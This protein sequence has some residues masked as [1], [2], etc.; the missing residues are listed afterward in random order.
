M[1][2]TVKTLKNVQVEVQVQETS[3]VEAV[4]E[5]IEQ[6]LPNMPAKTQK[7]IHSGK[8]LKREM[9]IKDYPDIKDGDKVIVIASKVVESSAPQPVAQV[10]EKA[11]ESTPVQQEAPEKPEPVYDNPSSK[12][13]IGQELQDNVNRI[14]EM[15]F[16]RSMVERAM[17]A[18]FNN[19]ERA[20][21]FLSTGHIPEPEAMG[22]DLPSMEH[23]G[24]MPRTNEDVIQML[25]SHPMFEQLRQVVQSDPQMLQQ[26]LDNIGRNNPE[27]LQSIIEHQDEFMELISSGAEVEPF[28]MPLERPDSVN[29]ENNPNIISLTESEMESVQRLEA[30]GFP[31]P[32]V[33]EAFLACDK[34]EQLAANYLLEHFEN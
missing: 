17:A 16:E 2:L 7:L 15:G 5:Q 9:Q 8:I 22:M 19:P 24:D 20:V 3:T 27:L 29:D 13:L 30:L 33:I 1:K 32:A 4:M 28:G 31:R 34:N 25:Q 6:L 14:C 26:L 12:L 23:S 18:A 21:E 10:E 11:P